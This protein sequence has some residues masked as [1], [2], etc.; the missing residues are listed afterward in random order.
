M[1]SNLA[2]SL[3]IGASVGAAVSGIN[4]VKSTIKALGDSTQSISQR[5]NNL[6][7]L[8]VAGMKSSVASLT[9]LG[10]SVVGLAKPAIEFESAMADVRKVVDF[11]TPDGFKKLS[12]ELLDLI[13]T[14]PMSAKELAT[15]AASGGQLGVAEEDIKSFTTTIAKMS[16]A[17]D[18][19]AEQSGDAMAKLANVYKIPISEIGK[20]GDAINELSNNSPAKASDIVNTLSRIGGTAKQFGLTETAATALSNTFISLGK[21]P[22]VAGTAINGMLTKLM[23]AEK[24]GKAFQGALKQVGISAKQLKNNIAKDGQTALTDFL[25]RLEKL[26]KDKAMGVLVDL[27]G[28]EYADDVAVLAGNVDLLDKS[29]NTLQETDE[30]GTLKYLGSME[31]EFATRS[32]TTQNSLALLKNSVTKLGIS[33]GNYVLPVINKFVNWLQPIILGVSEWI[34]ANES[35]MES[36]AQWGAY[37]IAG[38]GGF[39]LITGALGAVTFGVLKVVSVLSSAWSVVAFGSKVIGSMITFALPLMG[40]LALG[41][42]YLIGYTIKFAG[43]LSGAL[44]KGLMLA[45]KTIMF[46]GRALLMNPIGL[47]VTAIGIAAFVIYQYWEPIKAFFGNLWNWVSTKFAE[48]GQWISNT[49]TNVSNWFSSI[50]QAISSGFSNGIE[51]LDADMFIAACTEIPLF[52]PKLEKPM[53][54]LDATSELAAQ[55]IKFVCS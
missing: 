47:A 32:A 5:F 7:K 48:A 55:G 45:G 11:K 1:S 2:I 38:I 19:S 22:E 10:G 28:R 3:I 43:I 54:F 21:S 23:T 35:L 26:P 44:V 50:W 30:N 6:S 18:M 51:Q 39:S 14:I 20:L 24:G 17:F 41:F 27:F 13:D 16:V 4:Q 15:I 53:L 37:I 33:I 46:V 12:K 49:W 42:G 36:I 34:N 31:K 52:L 9:A 8:S 29:L 40:K 25:K